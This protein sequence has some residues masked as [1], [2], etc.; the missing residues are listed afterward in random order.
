MKKLVL[1][2]F[3]AMAFSCGSDDTPS[4][5]ADNNDLTSVAYVRGKMNN[6]PFD[7][8]YNNT[9]NDTHLYSGVNGY[10]GE[11]FDRWYH[12]AG[13]FTTFN[14]PAFSPVFYLGWNNMYYGQNGDEAG[15]TAAFYDT[16]GNLPTN[17]LT[18]AQDDAHDPGFDISFESADG[19]V[20][21]SLIGNQS[22]STLSVG[23][24]TE[25][26]LNGMQTKTVWG[27]FSGKMYNVADATDVINVTEGTYKI[28]LV[29]YN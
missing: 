1:F 3:A 27:T 18:A 14:P 21:S 23:G 5:P 17:Y 25:A 9:A 2:M 28:I 12:Y 24:S 20:Y 19:N 6:T 7:Y 4:T 15:E 8:T 22:G 29:E 10:S 16:V 26:V 13:S 11:G